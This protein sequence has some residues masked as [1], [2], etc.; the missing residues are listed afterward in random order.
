LGDLQ[1]PQTPEQPIVLHLVRKEHHRLGRIELRSTPFETFDSRILSG[2]QPA[3][4]P[5]PMYV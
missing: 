2:T 1:Q 4:S 3:N 5:H